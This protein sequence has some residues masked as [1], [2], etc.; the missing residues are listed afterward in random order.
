[1]SVTAIQAAQ[2]GLDQ[3]AAAQLVTQATGPM[4]AELAQLRKL[5]EEAV[6]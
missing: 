1:M 6:T 5:R 2:Q 4:Y 3:D